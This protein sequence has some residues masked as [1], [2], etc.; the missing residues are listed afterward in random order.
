MPPTGVLTDDIPVLFPGVPHRRERMGARG[1]RPALGWHLAWG[2]CVGIKEAPGGTSG[3]RQDG[4]VSL[5]KN[6]D[7]YTEVLRS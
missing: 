6:S 7:C 3:K 4:D 2:F 5:S 1:A